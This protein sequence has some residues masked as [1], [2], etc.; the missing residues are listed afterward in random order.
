MFQFTTTTV[1]NSNKDLTTGK[2]LWST[3]D[4]AG[5]KPASLH[6]KRV[7]VFKAPQVAAIYKAVAN[8]P[9]NAKFTFDFSQ[10]SGTAGDQYRIVLYVGLTQASQESTY[11]ND[12]IYKGRPFSVDFV[13]KDS[14]ANTVKE[15]VRIINKY[16]MMVYTRKLLNVS[17]SGT[18]LTIEA[19]NEYQRFRMASIEEFNADAYHGMGNYVPVRTLEDLTE[20]DSNAEVTN[21]A[22]GYFK[23]KEGFGT[24][25]YLMHNLRL[26]TYARTRAFATNKDENPVIGKLYNQYTLY[27]CTNRG[28]LGTNAV[29]D[30]VKSLTTHVFYV[31]QDL[32]SDFETALKKVSELTEAKAGS[33]DPGTITDDIAEL[34]K[35][36]QQIQASL[37]N[38]QDTLTAGN[39]ITIDDTTIS[40]KGDGV[41][42]TVDA[43]GIKTV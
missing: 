36:V 38:K 43:S 26:P 22:E 25:S 2:A 1:I 10:I 39:G 17:Y 15:L 28:I 13:W 19:T 32:A 27:Y 31:D 37:A 14:A 23:G 6:V 29:G 18:F 33:A 3:E 5:S 16:E 7:G 9:E 42:I 4:A 8:E 35:T 11:A 21:A 20:A 40:A 24:Y 41:T 34:T 30:L 12:L